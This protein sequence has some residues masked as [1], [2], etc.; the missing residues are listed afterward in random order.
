M[1]NNEVGTTMII[2]RRE[3]ARFLPN[4]LASRDDVQKSLEL[5]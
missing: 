2:E 3:E 5:Q 1:T 4:P